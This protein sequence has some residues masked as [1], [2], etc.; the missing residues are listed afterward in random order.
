MKIGERIHYV[1]TCTSTNDMAKDLADFGVPEG[2]V[3]LAEEQTSGKGRYRRH[4]FSSPG[5]GLYLSVILRP[6]QPEISLLTLSAGLAVAEALRDVL[7]VKVC[8]KWPNDLLW[9]GKKLGGILSE[10]SYFGQK[11]NYVVV[12]IGLNISH[13]E[14]DFPP[15][16]RDSAISLKQIRGTDVD[17]EMFLTKLWKTL[18]IWYD[19]YVQKKTALIISSFLE[20]SCYSPGHKLVAQ[21]DNGPVQGTF[22]GLDQDGG[23]VLET[24]DG[25]RT[26]F[27]VEIKSLLEAKEN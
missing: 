15:G 22:M 12:G 14:E 4:W 9:E 25:V 18:D 7:G 8:L 19:F 3:V 5:K 20:D 11:L 21:T 13:S 10:S 23:I 2:T 6:K 16:L 1:P 17:T 24:R 27:S 26:Y